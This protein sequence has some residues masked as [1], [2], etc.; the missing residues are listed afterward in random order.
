[1]YAQ[2]W[3]KL[4]ELVKAVVSYSENI[5]SRNL[6]GRSVQSAFHVKLKLL[7]IENLKLQIFKF[8]RNETTK[9]LQKWYFRC[10]GGRELRN[11]RKWDFHRSLLV[12]LDKMGFS[13]KWDF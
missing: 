12:S 4:S 10:F 9:E 1:M 3:T 11:A 13:I 8:Q 2:N 7:I 5:L 6:S